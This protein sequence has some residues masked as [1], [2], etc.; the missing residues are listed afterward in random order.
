MVYSQDYL[1]DILRKSR[2]WY[3]RCMLPQPPYK[4]PGALMHHLAEIEDDLESPVMGHID[5][6]LVRAQIRRGNIVKAARIFK[7]G[8]LRQLKMA[9]RTIYIVLWCRISG[10]HVFSKISASLRVS[11]TK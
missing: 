7:Q 4:L 3:I 6:P 8:E 5:V 10:V 9:C 2:Q 11:G 1:I